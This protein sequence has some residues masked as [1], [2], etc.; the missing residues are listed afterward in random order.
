MLSPIIA[1]FVLQSA[2]DYQY[3]E[4]K[5]KKFDFYHSPKMLRKLFGSPDRKEQMDQFGSYEWLVG[6]ARLF[7]VYSSK[8]ESA[9]EADS[10]VQSGT[11]GSV[12]IF[13]DQVQTEKRIR[14]TCGL[15]TLSQLKANGRLPDV[16]E[17]WSGSPDDPEHVRFGYIQSPYK[18]AQYVGVKFDLSRLGSKTYKQLFPEAGRGDMPD[19]RPLLKKLFSSG[20]AAKLKVTEI[21][22]R[23]INDEES[24]LWNKP[25][26]NVWPK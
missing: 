15:T 23:A 7:A 20:I 16:C 13:T 6:G 3:F 12:N 17:A 4:I 22:F 21:E 11:G 9:A 2:A 8:D 19:P 18:L 24:K 14:I 10:M 26:R 1:S 5:G 25:V